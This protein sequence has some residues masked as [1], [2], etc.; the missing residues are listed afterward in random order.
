LESEEKKIGR[1][2]GGIKNENL[3][4]IILL[5][6]LILFLFVSLSTSMRAVRSGQDQ[7]IQNHKMGKYNWKVKKKK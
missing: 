5:F 1:C 3:I 6:I 2:F 4:L 7:V